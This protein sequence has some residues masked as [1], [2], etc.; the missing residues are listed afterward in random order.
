VHGILSAAAVGAA[1]AGGVMQLGPESITAVD[2]MESC[3]LQLA[4][5]AL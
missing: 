5:G 1:A 2:K 4:D 3:I